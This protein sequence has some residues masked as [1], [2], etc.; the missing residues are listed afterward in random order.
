MKRTAP[1]LA[2]ALLLVPTL[3]QAHF[4]WAYADPTTKTVRLEIAESPGESIAPVLRG[5]QK[6]IEMVGASDLKD[7]GDSGLSAKSSAATA[8][9]KLI[10]GLHGTDLVTWWAKAGT[11]PASV[12][13]PTG[14]EFEIVASRAA[15][16]LTAKLTRHGKP[17]A[18]AEIEAYGCD[19]PSNAKFKTDAK[20]TITIPSLNS[21]RLA[22]GAMLPEPLSGEFNG[23]RYKGKLNLVSMTVNWRK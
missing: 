23:T 3:A 7:Q 20:G 6:R 13:K 21:G 1:T 15:H 22:L 16:G 9:F 14:Q 11:T 2:A 17:I 10:Y 18:N 8:Q 19:L 12:A 4:L 5:L